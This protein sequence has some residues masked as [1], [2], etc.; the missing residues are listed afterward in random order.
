MTTYH[1]TYFIRRTVIVISAF[2]HRIITTTRFAFF[3]FGT[4]FA[5]CLG[6][7]RSSRRCIFSCCLVEW[8]LYK[9]EKSMFS[10]SVLYWYLIKMLTV[11]VVV[12]VLGD[13]PL[14]VVAVDGG[15]T[16]VV[17]GLS[18]L[19]ISTIDA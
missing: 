7:Q 8:Q 10:T 13:V 3:V 4:F 12:G 19:S 16:V 2:A 18:S 1:V 9:V 5:N 14:V 11:T 6:R 15:G 17:A